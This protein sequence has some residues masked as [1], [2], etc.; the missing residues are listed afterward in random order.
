MFDFQKTTTITTTF[1]EKKVGQLLFSKFSENFCW[2]LWN[3]K[4]CCFGS[5]SISLGRL[6]FSKNVVG[7]LFF[8]KICVLL[9]SWEVVLFSWNFEVLSNFCKFLKLIRRF[10]PKNHHFWIRARCKWSSRSCK[11]TST[12]TGDSF[13]KNT[14]YSNFSFEKKSCSTSFFK[15]F[16]GFFECNQKIRKSSIYAKKWNFSI[17]NRSFFK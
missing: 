11:R 9:S 13:S 8:S 4:K 5:M 14:N 17:F 3:T 6:Y 16:E 15:I 1:F 10:F 2:P 12:T 7:Q